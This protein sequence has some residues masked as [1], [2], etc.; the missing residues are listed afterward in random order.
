MRFTWIFFSFFLVTASCTLVLRPFIDKHCTFFHIYDDVFFFLHLPLHVLFLFFLYT[1][2]SL[3]MQSLFLFHIWCLD[4]FLFKCFRKAGCES[5]SCHELS[6]YK[7]FQEFML[8]LNLFCNSTNGYKFSDLRLLS[9]F[10]CFLWFCHGLP[11]GEIVRGIFY[12]N[13][14]ILWQNALYL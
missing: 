10:I 3:C 6:S 1:H 11:K 9:Q 4:E 2:V 14:L 12:I 13:W 8:G 5:L 7:I